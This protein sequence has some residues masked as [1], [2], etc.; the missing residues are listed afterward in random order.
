MENLAKRIIRP[1]FYFLRICLDGITENYGKKVFNVQVTDLTN[2]TRPSHWY[3]DLGTQPDGHLLFRQTALRTKSK[4]STKTV[5]S[6]SHDFYWVQHP[7]ELYGHAI[8]IEVFEQVGDLQR[9]L[10][11][12]CAYFGKFDPAVIAEANKLQTALARGQKEKKERPRTAPAVRHRSSDINRINSVHRQ[13]V[14][15]N[16]KEK[17]KLELAG[18][19]KTQIAKFEHQNYHS[20]INSNRRENNDDEKKKVVGIRRK[21]RLEREASPRLPSQSPGGKI[22]GWDENVYSPTRRNPEGRAQDNKF[23]Q[24]ASQSPPPKLDVIAKRHPSP[25]L[26][27]KYPLNSKR[28]VKTSDDNL[29]SSF[30]LLKSYRK[31]V[32]ERMKYAQYE[33]LNR[34]YR[35]T[36]P[37]EAEGEAIMINLSPTRNAEKDAGEISSNGRAKVVV[38]ISTFLSD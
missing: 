19:T 38:P 20:S 17:A 5:I 25:Y 2:P 3:T 1:N 21:V 16:V 7:A 32:L 23:R 27:H 29:P 28:N 30:E 26:K 4:V 33:A 15:K 13:V 9:I 10:I 35:S 24:H 6:P 8:R 11:D 18:G 12:R 37:I 31:Q 34:R 36:P 14:Y 22:A